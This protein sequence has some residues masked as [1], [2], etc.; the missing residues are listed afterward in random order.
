MDVYAWGVPNAK[1]T[2]MTTKATNAQ[3]DRIEAQIE[4]CQAE[5]RKLGRMTKRNKPRRRVLQER[6][7]AL[8]NDLWRAYGMN[9]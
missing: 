7:A 9:D 3:R 6:I 4:A 5:L 8:G 2:T 1:E